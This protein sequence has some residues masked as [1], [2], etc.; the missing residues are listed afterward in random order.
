MRDFVP[1]IAVLGVGLVA[2]VIATMLLVTVPGQYVAILPASQGRLQILD[3]VY[4]A[5]GSVLDFGRLDNIV[6]AAS[7]DPEFAS[8]LRGSGAWIV[9]P[10]PRLLGC[11]ISPEEA[12]Q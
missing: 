12:S 7:D 2:L 11:S 10:S 9:I 1:A 4:Q 6:F 3:A 5:G 8:T